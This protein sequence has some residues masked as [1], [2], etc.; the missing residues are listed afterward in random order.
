MDQ[1]IGE[2]VENA[3]EMKYEFPLYIQTPTKT[4]A[5]IGQFNEDGLEKTANDY[6][7]GR[8]DIEFLDGKGYMDSKGQ[9]WIYQK[10]EPPYNKHRY[11]YM[12]ISDDGSKT[13]SQPPENVLKDFR[14]D[15]MV[16]LDLKAIARRS[17]A[18]KKYY[19]EKEYNDINNASAVYVPIEDDDDD[20]LKKCVK[21]AI[22]TKKI[23][24]SRLKSKTTESYHIPNMK[25]ALQGDTKMSVRY[26]LI[27]MELFGLDFELRM[28]DNGE[29]F[30]NPL[31]E[32]LIYRSW[33]DSIMSESE[34]AKENAKKG[35][36]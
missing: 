11:P 14:Y 8:T 23:D 32:P 10:E 20:F 18:D 28:I 19:N 27:W 25:S 24:I 2:A 5:V 17:S 35:D 30:V 7:T 33:K 31:E 13:M 22:L 36:I 15:R 4:V 34:I 29:D 12:W 3:G 1:V 21:K 26:F 6:A 9:I 16:N